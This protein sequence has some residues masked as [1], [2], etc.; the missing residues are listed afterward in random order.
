VKK[1]YRRV[2]VRAI[3]TLILTGAVVLPMILCGAVC[4]LLGVG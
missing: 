1:L 3:E 4:A 2:I